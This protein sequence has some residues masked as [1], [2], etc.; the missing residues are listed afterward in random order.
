MYRLLASVF[1][2]LSLV[3]YSLGMAQ[4]A[5]GACLSTLNTC[6]GTPPAGTPN[7]EVWCVLN[8]GTCKVLTCGCT[9]NSLGNCECQEP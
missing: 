7:L 2:G 8:G 9:D 5:T 1:F 3:F 6:G 4:F